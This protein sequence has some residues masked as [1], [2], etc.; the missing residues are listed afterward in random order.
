MNFVTD[1]HFAASS[2]ASAVVIRRQLLSPNPSAR[3]S[4][5]C[6]SPHQAGRLPLSEPAPLPLA[7]LELLLD[8]SLD[9]HA[10]TLAMTP[11]AAPTVKRPLRSP[12]FNIRHSLSHRRVVAGA[13]H[14]ARASSQP[15]PGHAVDRNAGAEGSC[16]DEV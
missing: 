9:P 3:A 7:L 4:V 6:L 16:L 10:L 2:F 1:G 14:V 13:L 11:I 5:V 8:L 12:F 15:A